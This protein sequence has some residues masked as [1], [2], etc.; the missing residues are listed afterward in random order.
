MSQGQYM[1]WQPAALAGAEKKTIVSETY[2]LPVTLQ[3]NTATD[4]AI[5]GASSNSAYTNLSDDFTVTFSDTDTLI[6]SNIAFTPNV[7]SIVSAQRRD[8]DGALTNIRLTNVVFTDNGDDT[9]NYDFSAA[10]DD[11]V[12]TDSYIIW[13]LGPDKSRDAD[14]DADKNIIQNPEWERYT[15]P[16]AYTELQPDDVTYDEGAVIDVRGY[17]TLNYMFSKS[18]SDADGSYLKAI[19]LATVDGAMDY[20]ENFEAVPATGV[21]VVSPKVY[22]Y[23]AAATIGVLSIDTKGMPFM[24]IDAAKAAD[25]GTDA[26]FTGFIQKARV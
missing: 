13:M 4:E 20:Q 17:N 12:T 3:T 14:L 2:P 24:R 10:D 7:N 6:I 8:A 11:F 23:V 9:Y 19:F 21:T 5:Q 15:A 1:Y 25:G 22:S 26:K 16:E 18:V